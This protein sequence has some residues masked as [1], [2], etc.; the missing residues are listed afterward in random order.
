M[1]KVYEYNEDDEYLDDFSLEDYPDED[2]DENLANAFAKDIEDFLYSIMR[3]DEI[4][5]E[6]FVSP[7]ALRTHFNKHCIGHSNRRS[8]RGRILYDFNDNSKYVEYERALTEK[9]KDTPYK[10]DSL[11][12]YDSILQH[13]KK[14]FEGNIVVWFTLSC[15]LNNHG[16]VSLAFNAFSSNVT[17]NYSGGNTIDVCIKNSRKKTIT[18]YAIDAH[19][20]E[21]RLN[22][23]LSNYSDY[24]GNPFQINH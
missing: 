8:T 23:I 11:Y 10:I 14:L 20:V 4:F 13:M 18:L 9:I 7:H 3:Q 1:I 5:E 24:N 2:Y 17:R 21:R 19:D 15:G 6:Q 12:D 16:D 22:N